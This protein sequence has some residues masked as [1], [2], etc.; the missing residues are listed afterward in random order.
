MLYTLNYTML[1]INFIAVKLE[2]KNPTTHII[3]EVSLYVKVEDKRERIL[4]LFTKVISIKVLNLS[5]T[6]ENINIKL[7]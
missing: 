3:Q 4:W 6:E 1:Y 2:T 5:F 7:K